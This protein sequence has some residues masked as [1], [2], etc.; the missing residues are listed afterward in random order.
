MTTRTTTT[1]GTTQAMDNRVRAACRRALEARIA[2]E[3]HLKPRVSVLQDN[4][5]IVD[6][7]TYNAAAGMVAR[8]IKHIA[9]WP[10][11][12][13]EATHTSKLSAARQSTYIILR[14]V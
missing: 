4:G 2:N 8:A 7:I 14:E 12:R 5:Y 13:I 11:F 10:G 1:Q 3:T 9:T 6:F